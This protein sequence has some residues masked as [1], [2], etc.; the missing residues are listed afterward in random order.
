MIRIYEKAGKT[1]RKPGWQKAEADYQKWLTSMQTMS[2]GIQT[3]KPGFKATKLITTKPDRSPP[4][5]LTDT[6]EGIHPPRSMTYVRGGGTKPVPRPEITYA[7]NP[8]ML[9]RELKARERKF[10]VAPAYNKGGD[11]YV[12]E[13]SLQALLSSNKR[14]S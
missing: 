13:E 8:E 3:S 9:A 5:M 2:S 1:K 6:C 11:T 14:R 4:R 10:N 12:T 7:D